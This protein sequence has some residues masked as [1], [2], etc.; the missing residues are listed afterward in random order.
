VNSSKLMLV[1]GA[2][3][4]LLIYQIASVTEAPGRALA[5]LQYC[6]LADALLGLV[7]SLVD[8]ASEK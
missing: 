5:V 6:L 1:S 8:Y 2:T 4:A 7:G 3:A